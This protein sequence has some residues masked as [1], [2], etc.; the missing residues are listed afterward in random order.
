MPLVSPFAFVLHADVQA[1]ALSSVFCFAPSHEL[2]FGGRSLVNALAGARGHESFSLQDSPD[3]ES[4][5]GDRVSLETSPLSPALNLR[6]PPCSAIEPFHR[7]SLPKGD[8][9]AATALSSSAPPVAQTCG[10]WSRGSDGRIATPARGTSVSATS[11]SL[12]S[13]RPRR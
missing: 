2:H 9:T 1:V 5:D 13:R 8:I 11:A 6:L 10:S 3:R 7:L 4:A 12:P